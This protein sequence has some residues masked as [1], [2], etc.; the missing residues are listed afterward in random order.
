MVDASFVRHVAKLLKVLIAI[1][2][3][4]IRRFILS[5]S[6]R[7]STKRFSGSNAPR[8]PFFSKLNFKQFQIVFGT[9]AD[10]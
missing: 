7:H 5:Q 9:G 10:V 1:G 4:D 8:P 6:N 2:K 3:H